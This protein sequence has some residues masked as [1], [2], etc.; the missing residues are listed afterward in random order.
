MDS[1][2]PFQ[3]PPQ[4]SLISVHKTVHSIR[5]FRVAPRRWRLRAAPKHAPHRR[6]RDSSFCLGCVFFASVLDPA[7]ACHHSGR[8]CDSLREVQGEEREQQPTNWL[9]NTIREFQR[10]PRRTCRF[11]DAGIFGAVDRIC[12]GL[13]MVLLYHSTVYARCS[14]VGF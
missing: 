13:R 14:R 9:V 3:S 7:G 2:I 5:G 10:G 6:P 12:M 8:C 1:A 4:L 11:G